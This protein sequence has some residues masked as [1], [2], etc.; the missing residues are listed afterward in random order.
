M[1]NALRSG[2]RASGHKPGLV[3]KVSCTMTCVDKVSSTPST[4][5][6]SFFFFFTSSLILFL[7]NLLVPISNP[8]I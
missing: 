5:L 3:D 4:E 1:E 6:K 2:G 7:R 8:N